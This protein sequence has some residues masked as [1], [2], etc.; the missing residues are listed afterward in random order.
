MGE[1]LVSTFAQR[2]GQFV[3]LTDKP[4]PIKALK[5]NDATHDY[6]AKE[7]KMDVQFDTSNLL[8]GIY[9]GTEQYD[10]F[11][12]SR[13]VPVPREA[14]AL[15]PFGDL[16]RHEESTDGRNEVRQRV[17][18]NYKEMADL[19]GGMTGEGKKDAKP[20]PTGPPKKGG[21]GR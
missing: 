15:N 2:V 9:T 19:V 7:L 18:E 11:G 21:R 12:S 10:L 1:W 14:V 4:K 6:E 3:G 20:D 5:W 17:V 13:H 16:V 8:V